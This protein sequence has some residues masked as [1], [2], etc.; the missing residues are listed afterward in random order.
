MMRQYR[1]IKDQHRGTILFFRLGDFYEMFEQDAIE[2]SEL[3]GLTLTQRGGV[4]MCGVP[5]HSS[6]NYL[7]RLLQ[8]G[9]KVALCEQ[10][11]TGN[12]THKSLFER[13]VTEV[14]TPGTL[15]E[16]VYLEPKSSSFIV[17]LFLDGRDW[18]A[19]L[20]DVSTGELWAG[21]F[22]DSD[23]FPELQ[24][25]FERFQPREVLIPEQTLESYRELKPL[26]EN[27]VVEELPLSWYRKELTQDE[28]VLESLIQD[29][30]NNES[31][32][33]TLRSLGRYWTQMLGHKLLPLKK[34]RQLFDSDCLMI[35]SS[36]LKN[37]E[38]LVSS[39]GDP[40]GTLFH[41]IDST[42]T[43]GGA[44]LLK[45]E[46]L[47]PPATVQKV[48]E[49]LK[50]TSWLFEH[51]AELQNV[52][53]VLRGLGDFERIL[54]RLSLNKASPYDILSL[55]NILE[56]CLTLFDL[57]KDLLP[58]SANPEKLVALLEK[59]KR[60]IHP[61]ASRNI[62][63]APRIK[64]GYDMELDRWR[65]MSSSGE[66]LLEELRDREASSLGLPLKLKYNRVLGYFYELTRV[67]AASVPTSLIRRQSLANAERFT[68][69]SLLDAEVQL[70]QS[71]EKAEDLD[72]QLFLDVRSD[73]SSYLS[74]LQNAS[75]WL[76]RVDY[77]QALAE[78][79]R[80]YHWTCPV[81]DSRPILDI[82]NGRHPVVET[83]L[84]P[85]CFVPNDLEISESNFFHLVTGPNMAGK[86]TYLRQN[87]LIVLLAHMGSFVPAD[88]A[89][90][91]IVDKIFCRV[92][93]HD[94][95]ARGD[96]T[97]LVEM[98][99]T[100]FIL[101]N[102]TQKSLIIMDEVGRG[103]STQDGLA[104]AWA[105]SEYLLNVI[106]ARTL[107]ST[108][109]HELTELSHKSLENVHMEVMEEGD[110]VIFLRRAKKGAAGSSYGIHAAKLAGIPEVVLS[111]AERLIHEG[112]PLIKVSSEK[113]FFVA[114]LFSPLEL[115][116]SEIVSLNL[117][118]ISPKDAHDY[119]YKIQERYRRT[120]SL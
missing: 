17:S 109:Y 48:T 110:E 64:D 60:S 117:D 10:I 70:A 46:M 101:R 33:P 39:S 2:V 112:L 29:F 98:K 12:S 8:L 119:L 94:R 118:K 86:S 56:R 92:G 37:L 76:K 113:R 22:Q 19:A 41:I 81:I 54:T 31:L 62:E 59:I 97:F 14:L 4:P 91:G 30:Q 67:Q 44:R 96:S 68:T 120:N 84:P 77:H 69:Q 52:R 40:S 85:G 45:Q 24:R 73:L 100:A 104:L 74:E 50:I 21:T 71:K 55:G 18:Q 106:R 93:A 20:W 65:Q 80:K 16:D 51:S 25:I 5:H 95:L 26:F 78:D 87:A 66:K 28:K 23:D 82:V 102:A 36:S 103:T 90:I 89:H 27:V 32:F 15:T 34:S 111:R 75:E 38:L 114:E 1:E 53:H 107:F 79:A 7:K 6:E 35:D 49:S 105:I 57:L 115:I 42:L 43:P 13:K 108:H 47:A 83:F 116:G 99:E 9:K 3:L 72:L 63:N 11:S 58:F 88:Q 61:E